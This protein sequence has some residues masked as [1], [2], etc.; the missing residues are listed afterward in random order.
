MGS[1]GSVGSVAVLLIA[2]CGGHGG[3]VFWAGSGER[4]LLA[5]LGATFTIFPQLLPPN[6]TS[7]T[8]LGKRQSCKHVGEEL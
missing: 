4:A 1:V 5:V 7:N 8:D 2:E 6:P 3:W